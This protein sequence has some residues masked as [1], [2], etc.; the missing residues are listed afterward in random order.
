MNQRK[1]PLSVPN[2][3]MEIADN[4]REAIE[5]GWIT[6]GKFLT[7][8]EEKFAKYTKSKYAKGVQSGTAGLHLALLTLGVKPGDE[9]IVPTLTFIAAVNPVTY[10]GAHPIFMDCDDSLNMDPKKLKKFLEEECIN[11]EGQLIN[12]KT[13]RPIKGIVLVHVFGNPADLDTIKAIADEYGLFILEDATEALGSWYTEGNFAHKHCGTIGDI[14]VFSFNANKIATTG[15][16][17]MVV[18]NNKKFIDRIG[19]L[20]TQAKSDPWRFKHDEIGYNYRLTNIAAAVGI[21]QLNHIEAFVKTKTENYEHYKNELSKD[22]LNMVNF[23]Q[24]T[25]PNYWFYSLIVEKNV[26]GL[27]NEELMLKLNDLG[28]QTRPIWG[29]IHKQKP[30]LKSQSYLIEKAEDY[31]NLVLNLPCSTNLNSE[32]VDYVIEKIRSLRK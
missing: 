9:I 2:L 13:N 14:G 11:Q 27:S 6:E 32:D 17:G 8:F 4:I 26:F 7:E 28:I 25:R 10:I 31:A 21:S 3:H 18:S 30:Y 1:I 5:T 29:L 22:G 20:S 15:G 16:G 23:S 12:K 24:G 19:F